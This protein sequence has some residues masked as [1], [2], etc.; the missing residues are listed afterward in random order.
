MTNLRNTTW[1]SLCA[2]RKIYGTKRDRLELSKILNLLGDGDT[3]LVAKLDR[4][5][6]IAADGAKKSTGACELWCRSKCNIHGQ[7]DNTPMGKPMVMILLAIAEFE[8]DTIIERTI[9]CII[10]LPF[11]VLYYLYKNTK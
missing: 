3:L 9:L 7:A 10:A 8:R 11:V 2:W 5:A 1:I 4:F 6:H